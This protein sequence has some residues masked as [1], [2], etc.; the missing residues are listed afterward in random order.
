MINVL[1]FIYHPKNKY[2]KQKKDGNF[3][4]FNDT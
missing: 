2:P 1:I 3:E 4:G